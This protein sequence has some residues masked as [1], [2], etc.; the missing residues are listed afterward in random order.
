M[1]ITQLNARNAALT[2]S[3]PC[4][5]VS[6]RTRPIILSEVTRPGNANQQRTKPN[7]TKTGR[8][9]SAE[10]S[11][12]SVAG[13]LPVNRNVIYLVLSQVRYLSTGYVAKP[14][15]TLTVNYLS[16][17]PKP[18]PATHMSKHPTPA[19]ADGHNPTEYKQPAFGF[20]PPLGWVLRRTP[21]DS[22]QR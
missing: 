6:R 1:G 5:W 12:R 13:T 9:L 14:Q 3:P 17:Q 15:K 4:C 22:C 18:A 2:F 7:K 20:T 16:C 21:T 8:K 10:A 11:K 19:G